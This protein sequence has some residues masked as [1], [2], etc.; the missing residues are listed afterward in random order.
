MF[1]QVQHISPLISFSVNCNNVL[2][3]MVKRFLV[4]FSSLEFSVVLLFTYIIATHIIVVLRAQKLT[5]AIH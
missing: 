4:A 1:L 2:R 3:K 5:F